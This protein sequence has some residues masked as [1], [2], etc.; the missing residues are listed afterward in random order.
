MSDNWFWVIGGGLLQI[1]LIDEARAL[2]LKVLVTDLSEHCAAMPHADRFEAVDI[3]DIEGNLAFCE[4]LQREGLRIAGVLAAGIDAPETMARLNQHLGLVGVSPEVARITQQKDLFRDALRGMGYPV[5][6]YA[7]VRQPGELD[8]AIRRIGFPLIVKPP[9]NSA[10]RDMKIFHD[11]EA[12]ACRA[13]FEQQL[14]RYDRLLL[15]TCWSGEEQTVESLVDIDGEV[16]DGFITDRKFTFQGGYAVETGLVHPTELPQ[17]QQA[18]LY[19]LARSLARDFGIRAGA[20][21]LDTIMTPQGPRLIEMAVRHSGGFD[22]QYLVPLATG[23]NVLRAAV[24][25][26]IQQKF[27]PELLR[28]RWERFGTTGSVWP[29]PGVIDAIEG[30]DEARAVSG[31]EHIF[32]RYQPGDRVAPYQDCAKRVAFIICVADSRQ[33]ARESL[34]QAQNR[35]VFRTS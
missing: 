1:P 35:L 30:L 2:G 3:F 6:E 10:S 14:G 26:A 12:D 17:E 9:A 22:C 21:K 20:V 16:H 5:P 13:F 34:R 11:G 28:P 33:Q 29:E 25:T 15:E 31:V 27:P 24:Y 8:E 18:E 32:L 19:A 23:K 7:V 4:R